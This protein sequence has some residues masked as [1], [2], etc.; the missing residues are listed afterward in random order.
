MIASVPFSLTFPWTEER[1]GRTPVR[2]AGALIRYNMHHLCTLIPNAGVGPD[3]KTWDEH[4]KNQR[5]ESPSL[6]LWI[7]LRPEQSLKGGTPW[8]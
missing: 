3:A 7:L 1:H 8:I 2:V 6:S 4:E 5:R